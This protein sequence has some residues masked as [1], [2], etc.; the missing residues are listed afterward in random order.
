M[1]S[2][3]QKVLLHIFCTLIIRFSVRLRRDRGN[4]HNR[5]RSGRRQIQDR[6][7]PAEEI[8]G[9]DPS[10]HVQLLQLHEPQ[11]VPLVPSHEVALRRKAPQV[12]RLRERLQNARLF[13]E[14]RQHAHGDEAARLPILRRRF[15]DFGRAGETRALQAYARETP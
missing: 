2:L 11:A 5:L 6:Q 4:R 12:Q 7:T 3:Y 9:R 13:A 1:F 8:A 14:S 10:T 15:Y